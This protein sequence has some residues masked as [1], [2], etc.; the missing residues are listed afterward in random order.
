ML[1]A[2]L[3]NLFTATITSEYVSGGVTVQRAREIRYDAKL[4]DDDILEIATMFLQIRDR[5]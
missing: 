1:A 4:D 2:L 5:Q 3:C